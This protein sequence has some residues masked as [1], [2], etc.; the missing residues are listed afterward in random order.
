MITNT[1][2]LVTDHTQ[3]HHNLAIEDA[4]LHTLPAGQAL[5]F[6][7]QNKHTVVIGAGQNAWREC[8]TELLEKE[9][10]TLARRSTGGGAVYHDMGNLNFS[11]IVPRADYD[12]ARQLK[13]VLNA[14]RALGID[15]QASGRND[16]TVDGRK[17]SGNAFRLLKESALH[18]GTLLV[19]I[20]MALVGRYLN[21]SQEK[22]KAKG[23]KSVPAR[24]TNLGDL[25]PVTIE[26]MK[27]AMISAFCAE[28]GAAPVESIDQAHIPGLAEMIEKYDGW[29]WNYGA[30]PVGDLHM[31]RRF[32]WGAVE[33]IAQVKSGVLTHVSVF[34]DAMDETLRER[35]SAALEGCPYRHHAMAERV[36]AID[37][38]VADWLGGRG[39]IRELT[40]DEIRAI[41]RDRMPDDF[42]PNEIR[43]LW[44]LENLVAQG[45]YPCYGYIV[46]GEIA[47][48]A[49]C[50]HGRKQK[51][52]LLDYFAVDARLR[53]Q[54]IGGKFLP[55]FAAKL[56]ER[57][58]QQMLLEV[59]RIESAKDETEETVRRLRVHFYEKHG[60][61]MTGVESKVFGV[62]YSAIAL[63]NVAEDEQLAQ[64][65]LDIYA[66]TTHG[67]IKDP[68][69]FDQKVQVWVTEED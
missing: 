69:L 12:V 25:A 58:V 54:G 55:G 5:L 48:Y 33:L 37:R 3:P 7:W 60:C 8:N 67:L 14:V 34:T 15:A 41:Y 46:A 21:V 53:G 24:V 40:L 50:V 26:S 18:H 19:S 22:L 62:D 43:P 51:S 13:V 31:E 6:L 47:S 57:G 39:T 45:V 36:D 4:L 52:A 23:V 63:G 35:L 64:D 2:I 56:K 17:F 20:D 28:Y 68:V 29:A 49:F 38:D 61:V 44:T 59:E 11:F 16:L 1:R 10:G 32:S 65:L 27:D 42:P 9:G 30:S 66:I